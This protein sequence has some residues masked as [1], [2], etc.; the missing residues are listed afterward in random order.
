MFKIFLV[1]LSC[2]QRAFECIDGLGK[3]MVGR[4]VEFLLLNSVIKEW[5]DARLLLVGRPN[6]QVE[7]DSHLIRHTMA[8]NIPHQ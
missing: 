5:G 1:A 8:I 4:R 3:Y 2:S 6:I 7:L